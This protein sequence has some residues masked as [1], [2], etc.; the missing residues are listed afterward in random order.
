M[1]RVWLLFCCLWA[2]AAAAEPIS[3][4]LIRTIQTGVAQEVSL[5]EI[6]AYAK[7]DATPYSGHVLAKAALLTLGAGNAASPGWPTL[8]LLDRSLSQLQQNS[9][10]RLADAGLPAGFDG[11][12]LIFTAVYA[13]VMTG[14]EEDA[15]DVLA[16]HLE[17]PDEYKRGVVLQALRN[18]GSQRA[19]DLIQQVGNRG[20]NGNLPENLL[21]DY[22]YPFLFQLR[23][24]WEQVRMDEKQREDLLK[25]AQEKPCSFRS[26]VAVYL[27]G[28]LA[29]AV[30]ADR[31]QT[32]LEFLRETTRRTCHYTRFFAIRALAL[33]S[34]ETLRFWSELYRREEDAWQRT[35]LARIGFIR[36]QRQFLDTALD[37]LST[38]PSQYVQWELMHGNLRLRR[39]GVWRSYW[40]LWQPPTLQFH[41]DFPQ[42]EGEMAAA[43]V[44]ALLT[45]L[46][47]GARP[48]H[49]WVR[50]HML[51]GLARHVQGQH[52][53]RL[54]SVF[55]ALPDKTEHWWALSPLND[56]SALPL[57]RYWHGLPAEK[58]QQDELALLISQLESGGRGFLDQRA[59]PCCHATREC[60]T[61]QLQSQRLQPGQQELRNEA[62]AQAWLAAMPA[63]S[64]EPEIRFSDE[65][66]RIAEVRLP[67]QAQVQAWEHLYG[68]WRFVGTQV[69]DD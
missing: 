24:Q 44:E 55:N 12:Q 8:K 34:P 43:D 65:L 1:T 37:W 45:W 38:E 62:E 7:A 26:D 4:R 11:A 10:D 32:E 2:G 27:L 49:L 13:L 23:N 47:T 52:T 61:A 67:G 60:L 28:F 50:N 57:L 53:R 42:Q 69:P 22:H 54:L 5:A 14:S 16:R 17:S 51:Y 64:P 18:I 29:P 20:L 46:E 6:V 21:A 19:S 31:D 40:D 56:P 63:M 39:G 68:C 41:L 66:E 58:Q 30:E 48:Q 36:Y 9:H 35:Q 25:I 15:V 33:R 3:W 59:R